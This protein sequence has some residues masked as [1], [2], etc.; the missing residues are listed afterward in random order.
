MGWVAASIKFQHSSQWWCKQMSLTRGGRIR[1]KPAS[2][3]GIAC[4][5]LG[6]DH[7]RYRPWALPK[8]DGRGVFAARIC[9]LRC[10]PDAGP[11]R[12]GLL[13][14]CRPSPLFLELFCGC[15]FQCWV[16][17]L[18]SAEMSLLEGEKICPVKPRD[19]SPLAKLSISVSQL[20]HGQPHRA[21][22][23]SPRRHHQISA[24]EYSCFHCSPA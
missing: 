6:Q 3:M 4:C 13:H 20:Y 24:S 14:V 1:D 8:E 11:V 2:L 18:L 9:G 22:A 5:R 7:K 23:S 15:L 12:Y 10:D 19:A 21:H 16:K 17:R